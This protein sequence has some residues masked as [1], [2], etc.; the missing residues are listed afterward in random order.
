[1][2]IGLLVGFTSCPELSIHIDLSCPESHSYKI[3]HAN[4]TKKSFFVRWI[5]YMAN[6]LQLELSCCG[7][8]MFIYLF[9][10]Y[11]VNLIYDPPILRM[12]LDHA[13]YHP[14]ARCL[15]RPFSRMLEFF[16]SS[17]QDSSFIWE[18]YL[19]ATA[20]WDMNWVVQSDCST[21]CSRLDIQHTCCI[22]SE[23]DRSAALD[24]LITSKQ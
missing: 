23:N 13:S 14:P 19:H 20:N 10:F 22:E 12:S 11:F 5:G 21:H 16:T 6:E 7:G 9:S 18:F 24:I 2:L 1:M 3:I 8:L 17:G 4:Y 15:N